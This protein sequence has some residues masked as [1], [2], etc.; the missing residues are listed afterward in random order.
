[1]KTLKKIEPHR[2]YLVLR[3]S[4]GLT[5]RYKSWAALRNCQTVN[6]YYYKSEL[7]DHSDFRKPDSLVVSSSCVGGLSKELFWVIKGPVRVNFSLRWDDGEPVSSCDKLFDE[8]EHLKRRK[9]RSTRS[10]NRARRKP[11]ISWKNKSRIKR[12]I[13]YVKGVCFEDGEPPVRRKAFGVLR[14]KGYCDYD[15]DYRV[16]EKNWKSQSK[17]TNQWR[18]KDA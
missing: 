18:Q 14:S 13:H 17:R 8:R 10:W 7:L 4:T 16:I 9:K 11:S 3:H 5:F 12:H 6:P 15:C 1:M 2:P